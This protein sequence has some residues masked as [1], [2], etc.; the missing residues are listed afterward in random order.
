MFVVLAGLFQSGEGL[1][2]MLSS[3]GALRQECSLALANYWIAASL[4]SSQ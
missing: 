2:F 4:R 1:C 3:Y